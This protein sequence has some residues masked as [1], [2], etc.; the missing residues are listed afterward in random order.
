M[1]DALGARRRLDLVTTWAATSGEALEKISGL[2]GDARFDA[3]RAVHN[4]ESGVLSLPFAQEWEWSPLTEDPEWENAP[5]AEI[6]RRTWRY[7]DERVPFMRGMLVVRH[8]EVFINDPKA[9][10]AGILTGIIY[11][12]VNRR[13]TLSGAS[14]DLIAVV[15]ALDVAAELRPDDVALTVLRRCGPFGTRDLIEQIARDD[16]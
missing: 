16:S 2:V 8:V 11:D 15:S 14:G 10:D 4:E 9:S 6:V 3:D 7:R 13:L 1:R 5:R 12:P